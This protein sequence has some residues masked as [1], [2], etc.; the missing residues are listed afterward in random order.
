[1][2]LLRVRHFVTDYFRFLL[3]RLLFGFS[4]ETLSRAAPLLLQVQVDSIEF[5]DKKVQ[6]DKIE[7]VK[8]DIQA[9]GPWPRIGFRNSLPAIS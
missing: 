9:C 4:P 2:H 3:P 1:M 6:Q 8:K 5:H 7:W